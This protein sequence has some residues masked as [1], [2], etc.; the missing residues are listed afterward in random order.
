MMQLRL[1]ELVIFT[2]NRYINGSENFI[3]GLIISAY[4]KSRGINDSNH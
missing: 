3:G 4:D 2:V 1:I